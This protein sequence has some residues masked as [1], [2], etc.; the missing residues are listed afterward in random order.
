MEQLLIFRKKK[1]KNK[2]QLHLYLAQMYEAKHK[3]NIVHDG[4]KTTSNAQ[5]NTKNNSLFGGK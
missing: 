4:T 3:L 5:S 2:K 1:R